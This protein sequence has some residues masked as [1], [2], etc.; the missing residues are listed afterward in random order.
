[1]QNIKA[2]SEMNPEYLWDLTHLFKTDGDWEMAYADAEREI[3][4]LPALAGTLG[5]S[6]ALLCRALDTINGVARKADLVVEYAFLKKAGDNS[7]SAAQEMED[8]A[9]RLAVRLG[10]S[11]AFVEPEILSIDEKTLA[12][13][14]EEPTLATYRHYLEDVSRSRAHTLDRATEELLASL[15]EIMATPRNAFDMLTNADME[16]PSV[17]NEAGEELPLSNG[18]F[19]VFRESRERSVRQAAFEAYFGAY[20]KI[21]NTTAALY[22][23]SVKS[24]CFSA[25]VRH[26]GGALQAA[27][28]RD[29]VPVEVYDSLILAVHDS[30]P[31]MREYLELRKKALGLDRIDVYDLYAPIVDEVEYPMPYEAAQKL[32]REALAPLGEDYCKV[33]DRAFS[34]RWIDV[35]ENKGKESGA[36]SSGVYG[37]HPYIK[38]NYTDTL[39]DAFTLAHELGH[40]MHSYYSSEAQDYQNHDYRILVAEVASTVNEVLLTKHLLRTETEPRRRAYILN[41]FLEGFRTTVF[42]QTLF[43][44]FERKAHEMYE[45]G[46]ALTA[47]S[48]SELYRGLEEVYYEGADVPELISLEWSYIPHFYRAF[49]V[50]QYAT[51][52]SAAVAIVD[53]I[54]SSGDASDYRRFLTLGG[55]DYPLNELKEAGVDL[56]SPDAVRSAL[57]VFGETVRELS[58]LLDTLSK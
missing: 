37:V 38:L 53:R 12:A 44:E 3:G 10:A 27:L 32:V 43:A 17:K 52:F 48:L 42:R 56:T 33:L 30:L 46:G 28:F 23:G 4:G 57:R 18:S 35:Y 55:S 8:R 29:N 24:D 58:A 47:A 15:G 40:A 26:Y 41:H 21:V 34:E 54:L 20:R 51:G 9:I 5:E 14:M 11:V 19:S 22:A 45:K 13:Y 50:Y 36:F 31:M 25:S 39:D 49:Y 7:D 1:M 2:R 6:A 16:F